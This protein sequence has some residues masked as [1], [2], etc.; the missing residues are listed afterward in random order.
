MSM[1]EPL[2][3]NHFKEIMKIKIQKQIQKELDYIEIRK[4]E[5]KRLLSSHF[6]RVLHKA[7]QDKSHRN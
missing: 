2:T 5:F 4:M 3:V 1:P 6:D 7:N